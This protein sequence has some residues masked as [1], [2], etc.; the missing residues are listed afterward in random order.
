MGLLAWT[1]STVIE[2]R[3][4]MFSPINWWYKY[5]KKKKKVTLIFLM[6]ESHLV[7]NSSYSFLQ[8]LFIS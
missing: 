7:E 1:I 8:F 5:S 4:I 3:K 6:S 2:L